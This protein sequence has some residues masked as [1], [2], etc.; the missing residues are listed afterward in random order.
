[1]TLKN[2][3]QRHPGGPIVYQRAVPSDLRDRYSGK[4]IKHDL[5]TADIAHAAKQVEALNR[6]YEAEWA[7]LRAAPESSPQALKVHA[8]ALL[9]E[10]G[11]AP[12]DANDPAADQFF[13]RLENK[14]YRHAAGDQDRYDNATPADYLTPVEQAAFKA[15]QGKQLPTLTDALELHLSIHPQRSN[16]RFNQYQ[17]RAFA[18]LISVTGDKPISEFKRADARA[19]LGAALLTAKTA[20]VRRRLG[21]LSAVFSTYI[22]ENDLNIAN[23]FASLAIDREGH[24]ITKR[25]P[26]T[27][28]ELATL[29]AACRAK[30]DPMRWIL[31]MLAGTG[32]RLAEIVGLPLEDI[33]LDGEYPH[34]ILQVHPWRDIK[35]AKGIRGKKDRKVPL[36]GVALWAAQR[37]KSQA[38]KGQRFAFPQYTSDTLCKA[39]HASG[40]LNSWIKR[41]PLPH[42][43]HEL[44]HTMKDLLRDVQCP[45]DINDSITGHGAKDTG[46]G[47]GDG[48]KL[49][50]RSEWLVKALAAT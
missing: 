43:C 30:D 13:D 31:A 21:A 28:P 37:V 18:T 40:A 3:Y 48:Y 15:L 20:T 17:R 26:F 11:L 44:R 8:A 33:C 47:Y 22:K 10:Y 38:T 14:L 7:G 25:I 35:G 41:L 23:P 46:D 50:I 42:T 16:E 24:D 19:Y 6:R 36:V 34:V 1:M 39:T 2:T 49:R 45:K 27:L 4:T 12:G 32:A 5:K 29:E 9:S